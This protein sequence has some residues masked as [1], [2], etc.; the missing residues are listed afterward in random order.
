MSDENLDLRQRAEEVLQERCGELDN[1][2][3]ADM[4]RMV[5]ADFRDVRFTFYYE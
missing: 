2:P 5:G 4:Q 3:S 1:I